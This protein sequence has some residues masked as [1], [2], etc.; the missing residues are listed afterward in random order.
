MEKLDRALEEYEK[1]RPISNDGELKAALAAIRERELAL[2]DGDADLVEEATRELL[3]LEG[4]DPAAVRAEAGKIGEDRFEGIG[5]RAAKPQK[6]RV[7]LRFLIPAAALVAT[8][9]A[10]SIF[11][12]SFGKQKLP[13]VSL[14]TEQTGDTAPSS[15]SRETDQTSTPYSHFEPDPMAL[16]DMIRLLNEHRATVSDVLGFNSRWMPKTLPEMFERSA[17]VILG[18]VTDDNGNRFAE[19]GFW[20]H[21]VFSEITV[22]KSWRG[23]YR[24]GDTVTV[25]SDVYD[26]EDGTVS[27]LTHYGQGNFKISLTGEPPLRSGT[28]VILFLTN[29]GIK[30]LT[31]PDGTK[32][33]GDDEEIFEVSG[34]MTG[35]FIVEDNTV[36]S[37]EYYAKSL[38]EGYLGKD[39]LFLE[40]VGETASLPDFEDYLCYLEEEYPLRVSFGPAPAETQSDPEA[41]ED[42]K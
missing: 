13:D 1:E 12:S 26:S 30:D 6:K 8:V 36:Y 42:R 5:K 35:K 22:R 20:S 28:T 41:G 18:T 14:R 27:T 34:E 3:L 7:P 15:E 33:F 31:M 38:P 32:Y 4:E 19:K 23:P 2:P 40:D 9:A 37:Y 25:C 10:A 17:V 24:A 21:I 11:A 29:S 16:Y 39:D